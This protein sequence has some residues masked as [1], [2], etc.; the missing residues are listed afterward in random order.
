MGICFQ[1]AEAY[2]DT[3]DCLSVSPGADALD[4]VALEEDELPGADTYPLDKT[5]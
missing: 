2:S 1:M 3:Y 5:S 4:M